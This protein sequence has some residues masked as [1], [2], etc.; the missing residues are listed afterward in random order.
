MPRPIRFILKSRGL[1]LPTHTQ[2]VKAVVVVT[3]EV[4]DVAIVQI[5]EEREAGTITCVRPH[6][7]AAQFAPQRL[8]DRALFAERRT[9]TRLTLRTTI[10]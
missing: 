8:H 4:V 6:G 2:S 1:R 5:D 3:M 10:A 7:I 9:T